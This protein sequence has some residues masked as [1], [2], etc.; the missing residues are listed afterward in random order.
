MTTTTT[1]VAKPVDFNPAALA[2]QLRD[3]IR[4]DMATLMP[5]EMWQEF[6]KAEIERFFL[7]TQEQ[8]TY[9][10]HRTVEKPPEFRAIVNEAMREE[11][12]K[13]VIEMLNTEEWRGFWDG[14]TQKAGKKV[15]ELIKENASVIL[16]AVLSESMQNVVNA[17]LANMQNRGY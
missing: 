1:E 3:K 7:P 11:T 16:S 13:R 4:V 2:G 9:H 15:E 5:D 14:Q 8:D 6:L 12:K 17:M 10:T